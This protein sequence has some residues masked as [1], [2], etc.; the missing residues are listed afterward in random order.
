VR[1]IIFTGK[2]GTGKT[3]V[4]AAT[5]AR[6]AKQGKR[7]LVLSTDAAHNLADV[8]AAPVGPEPVEIADRLWGQ[9]VNSLRETERNWETI[10][11]WLTRL[12]DKA[13]LKDISTEEMLVFPGMEELLNLLQLREH[14][15]SG[16]FDV[17][18]VDCAP[19]GETLRLLSYPNV[20]NWWLEKI[21][22]LERRLI[23]FMR[24]VARLAGQV[25]LPP[26]EVLDSVERLARGLEETQRLVLDPE[27]TSV[28]IV[29]NPEK[30]V[31]AES[32]RAF[33]YLNL[34]GFST[35]AVVVNRVL[36]A[37]AGQGF[38]SGWLENQRK[39]EEE[40]ETNFRPLPILK[41][42][43]MPEEVIGL[44]AL[45]RFA[46]LL[47]ESRDPAAMLYRGRTETFRE[48]DGATLLELALPFMDR[49]ELDL[50]QTG[51]E[52][53]VHAGAYKRKVILPRS[54]AGSRVEGA[55]FADGRLV[56]RFGKRAPED[57]NDES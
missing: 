36:P 23:K 31:V 28:R 44:P 10:Q 21:F 54:L 12:L 39:H 38:F 42:P 50:T 18:V 34:F 15:Q 1:V 20:L 46:D 41:A 48:E 51:D 35:D 5:A 25:E 47:Y 19:T 24:P 30:M 49:E 11:G 32:K 2:G 26:D 14:T 33:T 13:H 3:S 56:I 37:E 53:T 57:R 8:L 16:R 9:E 27:I 55:K 29:L 4:A 7:T 45:E 6:L 52:L 40:I 43:M 17:V 22:P